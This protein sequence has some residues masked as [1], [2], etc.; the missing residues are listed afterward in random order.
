MIHVITTELT[1]FISMELPELPALWV[2]LESSF[3]DGNI[4]P[5]RYSTTSL[6]SVTIHRFS[7]VLGAHF[8]YLT[9]QFKNAWCKNPCTETQCSEHLFK[10]W[11]LKQDNR[12]YSPPTLGNTHVPGAPNL[13]CSVHIHKP[14]KTSW[15]GNSKF[16]W[17]GKF[18]STEFSNKINYRYN[19][20]LLIF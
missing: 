20:S 11:E 15:C 18:T 19:C 1:E 9:H 10:A 4:F 12:A 16:H 2:T 7:A 14:L 3:I 13:Q 17:V 5:V 8:T 6:F